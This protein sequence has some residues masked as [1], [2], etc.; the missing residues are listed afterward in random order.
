MP[1]HVS[2]FM[3]KKNDREKEAQNIIL[4]FYHIALSRMSYDEFG[5]VSS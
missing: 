4:F 5:I 2:I 3:I 1:F